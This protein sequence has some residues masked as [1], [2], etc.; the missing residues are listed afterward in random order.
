VATL[1]S[2]NL[3]IP[4]PTTANRIRVTGIDK[5]PTDAAILLRP[6]G[7][8][9]AGPGSGAVG[10]R[11]FE[12]EHHGGDEQA[13]Y[14][15]ARED[16]DAWAAEL[17]RPLRAG[18][19]GENLTTVGVDVT[20]AVIGE[21][22]RVGPNAVLEVAVPRIPCRT[23]ATWMG[24]KRWVGWFTERAWPGAYL[25]VIMSGEVRAGDP[26]EVIDR[27]EHGVTIGLTFRAVTNEPVH[28]YRSN[29]VAALPAE[30]RAL[31]ARRTA[32]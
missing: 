26:V 17:G 5:H 16:L 30:V 9:H 18:T 22:W 23:F 25:R 32:T 27:P 24:E 12:T 3:A 2:V 28:R 29:T 13:V 8:R 10:D 19:F 7:P 14:A 31:V 1:S 20:A 11:V 4:R 21:R 6:P 15:Y